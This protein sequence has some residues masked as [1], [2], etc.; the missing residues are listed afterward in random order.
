MVMDGAKAQ[1]QGDFRR[2]LREAG[3]H[4]RQTEPHTP[5]SNA[6]EGSIRELK[7]GVGREMVRSREPKRP[8]DDCLVR[9]AYVRSSTALEIFSLEGQFPDT[10]VKDQTSDISPLAEY[11]WYEW[12]KFRNTG[13]SFPD[14]K[15]WIDRY[16]GPAI[17][18]GPAMSRKV[19]K[20]NGDLMF[21]VSVRGLTLD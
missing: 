10:S 2:K 17:D 21:R 14:S 13:Q 12:V 20:I 8:W 18:I 19:L 16:L 15:E 11:A 5:K 7:R 6:A 9:K 1:I 3:C 4:I